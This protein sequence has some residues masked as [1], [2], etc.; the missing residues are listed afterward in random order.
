MH[1]RRVL[2]LARCARN[3]GGG[4]AI[5]TDSNMKRVVSRRL[6]VSEIAALA[7]GTAVHAKGRQ[8]VQDIINTATNV[9]AFEGYSAFTMRNIAA[10]LGMSLRNL[11]YYFQTKGDLFQAVVE[12]MLRSE[13]ESGRTAI[14]KPGLSPIERFRSFIDYSIRDIQNPLIR[15]FQFELWALATRDKFAA[16]CRDR[17]TQVY[18]EFVLQLVQPLTPQLTLAEQRKKAAMIL[19]LLQGLSL[20]VGK[21]VR[22]GFRIGNLTSTLRED[23]L[24]I[25][26]VAP[27]VRH[28]SRRNSLG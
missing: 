18:C 2:A 5:R 21:G 13:L 6:D 15:S 16:R 24:E 17:M 4:A 9:L 25:L 27:P 26:R 10:K 1:L 12:N 8:R 19:A 3:I 28:R 7:P 23:L 11:Q 20:L 22:S 14:D